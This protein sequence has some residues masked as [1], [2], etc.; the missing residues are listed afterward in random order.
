MRRERVEDLRLFFWL[1]TFENGDGVVAFEVAH[2]LD[3]GLDWEFLEDV[4]A[5]RFAD[6]HQGRK[7]EV[8]AHQLDKARPR[9]VAQQL[10]QGAKVRLMQVADEF[11]NALQSPSAIAPSTSRTNSR[12]RD[13]SPPS[14][15]SSAAVAVSS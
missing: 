4:L 3:E 5:G 12:L 13:A 14:R 2:A 11:V 9:L 1:Q 7:V 10:Q 8:R 15:K 6:L